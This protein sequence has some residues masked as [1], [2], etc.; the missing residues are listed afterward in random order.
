MAA[1][2]KQIRRLSTIVANRNPNRRFHTFRRYFVI[3]R[4]ST[5]PYARNICRRCEQS[6]QYINF[7]SNKINNIENL[8]KNLS[9]TVKATNMNFDNHN[10]PSVNSG[11]FNS[12]VDNFSKME[13]EQLITFSTQLGCRLFGKRD[14]DD[15][16][17]ET[18]NKNS[19]NEVPKDN[20]EEQKP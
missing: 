6:D 2:I 3:F 9:N 7:L 14:T 19:D 13:I 1:K 17:Q 15:I 5:H 11:N 4:R 8:V 16:K 12:D 18:N 10:N 20:E